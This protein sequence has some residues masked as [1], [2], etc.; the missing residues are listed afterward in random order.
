[1][2]ANQ[3]NFG[4]AISEGLLKMDSELDF[5]SCRYSDRPLL[6]I[7]ALLFPGQISGEEVNRAVYHRVQ[8]GYCGYRA[9][10]ICP[11]KYFFLSVC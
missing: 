3:Y 11:A 9:L 1:M 8:K 5:I 7:Q 2:D 6:G 4:C 10:R